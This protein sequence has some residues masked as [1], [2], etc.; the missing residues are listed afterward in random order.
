MR[1]ITWLLAAITTTGIVARLLPVSLSDLPFLPI[2][3]AVTPLYAATAALA[4]T[5]TLAPRAWRHR[6][7]SRRIIRIVAAAALALEA[8]W[9]APL[10]SPSSRV[11]A[12]QA[13]SDAAS[14]RVMTCNV[15]KGAASAGD[16]VA[17]VRDQ[18]VQVLALQETT[19][20]FVDALKAAGSRRAA[21]LLGALLVRRRVRQRRVERA[22][23]R[24][25]G[26]PTTSVRPP[27]PCRRAPLT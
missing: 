14:L 27:R 26:K 10:A 15:Y 12:A 2:L 6:R 16:I 8:L 18:H 5:L 20:P 19:V 22:A 21:S 17:A 23:A 3:A 24:R 9:L 25:R 13:N 1:V 11:E 7:V 4:L